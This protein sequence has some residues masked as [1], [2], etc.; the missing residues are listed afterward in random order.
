MT[1]AKTEFHIPNDRDIAASRE[2]ART[3]ASAGHDPKAFQFT[4]K[5]GIGIP[6]PPALLGII[7]EALGE[8]AKGHA[9]AVV[10]M[11][12][13]VTTQQAADILNV[14][15]PYVVSLADK[16]LLPIRM[17]GN[18]RRLPLDAVLAY[19]AATFQAAQAALDEISAIDQEL[20]LR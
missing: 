9:V 7:A 11:Q 1:T 4:G 20:G 2:L 12:A 15:R 5:E 3:M 13:E 6:L 10:P 19:K 16:G 8:L 18:Q 14:S 17:V